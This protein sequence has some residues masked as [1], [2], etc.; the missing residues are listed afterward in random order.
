MSGVETSQRFPFI[1]LEKAIGRA[2]ELYHADQRGNEMS[3][4]G[5]FEVWNYSEK[6]SGGYQTIAALKMYGLLTSI[7]GKIKLSKAGLDFFRDEREDQQLKRL[8]GFAM[9]PAMLRS[10]WILW[11][12][13]PPGDAL[14]RSYLKMDRNLSEQSARSVLSI[15]KDNLA[16][17]NFKGDTKLPELKDGMGPN[18]WD[19][20]PIKVGD[21]VQLD[22]FK[23]P[24]KVVF[25]SED[26]SHVRVYGSPTDIPMTE[27]RTVE[28]PKAVWK[29]SELGV[30]SIDDTKPDISVLQRGDRLEI[31]ANVDAAGLAKLKELLDYYE[32]ILNLLK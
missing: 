21:Y 6:S 30:Q 11:G 25:V 19:A 28:P 31:K 29:V 18:D 16:F 2:K 8:Q 1:N 26:E 4:P 5:A 10:L 22:R 3:I 17:A 9:L 15:Y 24:R 13:T 27:V 14:A 32:K 23:E 20:E 12:A 7:S